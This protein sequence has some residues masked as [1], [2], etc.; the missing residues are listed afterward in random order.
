MKETCLDLLFGKSRVQRRVLCS[1]NRLDAKS[2]R[3]GR[4]KL[5]AS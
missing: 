4:S 2:K 3:K 5:S 1:I